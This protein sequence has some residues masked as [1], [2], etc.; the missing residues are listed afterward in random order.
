M[1]F[2][3][4]SKPL[5]QILFMFSILI[6]A[7]L[8]ACSSSSS[9]DKDASNTPSTPNNQQEAPISQPTPEPEKPKE[10]FTVDFAFRTSEENFQ[11]N[12]KAMMEETNPH[13]TVVQHNLR[14]DEVIAGGVN[15]HLVFLGGINQIGSLRDF[16]L[17]YDIQ[18][19]A[20]KIGYSFADINPQIMQTIREW[21]QNGEVHA[22]PLSQHAHNLMFNKEIFDKFG[23]EYP[24]DNMTWDEVI[25]LAARVTG[26]RDGIT[27][28]GLDMDLPYLIFEQ[29]SVNVINDDGSVDLVN[30]QELRMFFEML[31]R[32][33]SIPGMLPDNFEE[34]YFFTWGGKFWGDQNYAMI[35]IFRQIPNLEQFDGDIVTYPQWSHLPGIGP[36][37]QTGLI[38]ITNIGDRQDELLKAI[39][40]SRLSKYWQREKQA[41]HAHPSVFAN[42]SDIYDVW[43]HDIENYEQ[44]NLAALHALKPAVV[45]RPFD[46]EMERQARSIIQKGYVEFAKL[47]KDITSFL[48]EKQ[49]EILA[50]MNEV[51]VSRR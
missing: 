43:G 15:P 14:T 23:V 41:R 10:P 29:L 1:K 22:L 21:S 47:E 6:L 2:E 45:P 32:I 24:R 42:V 5:R 34:R 25:E 38:A 40:D 46:P 26:E 11:D 19:A 9:N 50:M 44:F 8:V 51:R 36:G 12:Y 28:H 17:Q 3:F 13:L 4:K 49:E 18:Q 27:Y 39:L 31:E 16:E 35:P 37:V 33:F 7:I 30:H 20:D 48:A